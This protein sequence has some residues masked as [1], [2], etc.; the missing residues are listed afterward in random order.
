MTTSMKKIIMCLLAFMTISTCA[1]AQ[2][3]E[4]EKGN[5]KD[6]V[7]KAKA[8]NKT[9]YLDVYTT[10]CGPCKMMAKNYF[11][12]EE[13]GKIYNKDFVNVSIDAEKGE[14]LDIAKKYAVTGYPTNLFINPTTEEIIYKTMGMPGDKEGFI[15]NATTA[16]ME[17]NDPMKLAEYEK[18]FLAANYDEIF[19]KNYIQ[20]LNRLDVNRD[21]QI[22]AYVS[23]YNKNSPSDTVAQFLLSVTNTMN[24]KGFDFLVSDKKY[25]SQYI[26]KGNPYKAF[27][28]RKMYAT[29]EDAQNNN[30]EA[31]FL[32]ALAKYKKLMPSETENYYLY[33]K[34]Y[35]S[36]SKDETKQWTANT[37]Y[38][39]MLSKKSNEAFL[40]DDKTQL[41]DAKESINWQIKQMNLPEDK[42]QSALENTLKANPRYMHI[43]SSMASTQL[44]EIA[45]N[46]FE[47]KRNDKMMIAKALVWAKKAVDLSENDD[48]SS[49]LAV[50]DTYASLLY[51]NGKKQDAINIETT[52]IEIA[53][54]ENL[55]GVDSFEETL[56]KMKDGK[57]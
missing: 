18:K 30:S 34:E 23:K 42:Q 17:K 26:I 44:N 15:Q 8:E 25:T 41:E 45:W 22:D 1:L 14:G 49:Q 21:K 46:T 57:Y 37:E 39:D 32:N 20:K 50:K 35:Y 10:W 7:S 56:Q 12:N 28:E 4:F 16:L 27:I 3:I 9:I 36:K 38:A 54:K 53:K 47:Q 11:P 48:I 33:K 40:A 55:D 29:I 24:N 52:L 51:A 5:W 6:A 31:N 19:L 2:G 13:V 43:A